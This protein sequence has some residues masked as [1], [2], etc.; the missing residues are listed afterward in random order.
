MLGSGVSDVGRTVSDSQLDNV[1]CGRYQTVL[2]TAFGISPHTY[3][4]PCPGSNE[5]WG[6]LPVS[7]G[8][9]LIYNKIHWKLEKIYHKR[10]GLVEVDA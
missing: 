8:R 5:K 3:K 4:T 2:P 6:D 10:N 7:V 1:G 9:R